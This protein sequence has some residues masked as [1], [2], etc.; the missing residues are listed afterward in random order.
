MRKVVIDRF[1]G[2]LT[3]CEDLATGKM[4]DFK[5]SGLPDRAKEGTVLSIENDSIRIDNKCTKERAEKIKS[6]MDKLWK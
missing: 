1:E 6:K 3:V 4:M 2:D 5:K